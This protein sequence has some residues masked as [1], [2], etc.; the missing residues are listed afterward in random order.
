MVLALT[1]VLVAET[2]SRPSRLNI[3]AP[4]IDSN[5]A[6]MSPVTD[7]TGTPVVT[8]VAIEAVA[9]VVAGGSDSFVIRGSPA[10][11]VPSWLA[12]VCERVTRVPEPSASPRV[13]LFAVVWFAPVVDD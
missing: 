3:G 13:G 6:G 4:L 2:A 1:V 12:R 7:I 11:V 9:P 8:G 5:G 10:G